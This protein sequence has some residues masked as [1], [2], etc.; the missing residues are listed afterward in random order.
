[1]EVHLDLVH[2][3]QGVICP[4]TN[5]NQDRVVYFSTKKKQ[6]HIDMTWYY[7][8]TD[9]TFKYTGLGID[10]RPD[11]HTSKTAGTRFRMLQDALEYGKAVYQHLDIPEPTFLQLLLTLEP[12]QTETSNQKSSRP[13]NK[14]RRYRSCQR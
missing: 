5:Q 6:L 13:R 7:L 11:S 10:R 14:H 9:N 3:N 2:K 1:M 4:C 8:L 12:Q